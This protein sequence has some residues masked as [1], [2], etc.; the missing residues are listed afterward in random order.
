MTAPKKRKSTAT[1][2][3]KGKKKADAAS[4]SALGPRTIMTR[5]TTVMDRNARVEAMV[6][7]MWPGP[8]G[9]SLGGSD[10][11]VRVDRYNGVDNEAVEVQT[12]QQVWE[13][14]MTAP[15]PP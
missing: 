15:S 5:T 14:L 1:G 7:L 6:Q 8:K 9:D 3:R 4:L 2:C 12:L 13:E 11:V 10:R